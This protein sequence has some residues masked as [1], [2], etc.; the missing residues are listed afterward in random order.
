MITK[1]EDTEKRSLTEKGERTAEDSQSIISN[2]QNPA[3]QAKADSSDMLEE[4][5]MTL[6][7]NFVE[8]HGLQDE[9]EK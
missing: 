9:E 8:S 2:S 4:K 3:K 5:D 7:E 1:K 6:A